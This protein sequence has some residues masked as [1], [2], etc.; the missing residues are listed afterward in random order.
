MSLGL[1]IL[2]SVGG[3]RVDSIALRRDF[4]GIIR[5]AQKRDAAPAARLIRVNAL[6]HIS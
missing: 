6:F 1:T 4:R 2:I 5:H 3:R